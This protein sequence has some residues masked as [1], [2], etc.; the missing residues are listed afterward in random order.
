MAE[1]VRDRKQ[2]YH[3]SEYSISVNGGCSQHQTSTVYIYIY[4]QKTGLFLILFFLVSSYLHV[5]IS[6]KSSHVPVAEQL[7][8]LLFHSNGA[9]GAMWSLTSL[10]LGEKLKLSCFCQFEKIF[11]I[12][13]Y[14]CYHPRLQWSRLA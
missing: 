2:F 3:C 6:R 13:Y 4:T 11:F 10:C 12:F 14:Y 7:I 8:V 1:Y 9:N 5:K